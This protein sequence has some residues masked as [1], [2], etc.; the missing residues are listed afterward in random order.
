MS[1]KR[2]H[3]NT[4]NRHP[5][6][7]YFITYPKSTVS[8]LAFLKMFQEQN[9]DY[10]IICQEAHQDGTPHLHVL[11]WFH[12][13]KTKATLLTFLRRKFPDDNH[14][15][16]VSSIRNLPAAIEYCKK[17]DEDYIEEPLG[18]PKKP[19]KYPNWMVSECLLLFQRH[20][21]DMAD[22]A[23]AE[24]LILENRK[25]EIDVILPKLLLDLPNSY[26]QCHIL[27]LELNSICSKLL[28]R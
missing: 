26:S 4:S 22:E 10:Y 25:K 7:K 3:S 23:K 14:R 1:Y 17:E 24:R 13:K 5:V 20:P 9:L 18:L 8:K 2:F 27:E 12:T 11:A 21:K 6:Q 19:F 15:I 28:S 16:H